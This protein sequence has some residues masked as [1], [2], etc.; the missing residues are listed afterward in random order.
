MTPHQA[1]EGFLIAQPRKALEQRAV[2]GLILV[3]G[4]CQLADIADDRTGGKVEHGNRFQLC[5]AS[6]L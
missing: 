4:A 3:W 1:R 6:I 5:E 2:A